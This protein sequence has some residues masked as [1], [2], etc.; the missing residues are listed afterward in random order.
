[1]PSVFCPLSPAQENPR[2]LLGFDFGIKFIGIAVGQTVTRT[3]KPL[4]ALKAH[5][6]VPK[7]DQVKKIIDTWRPSALVVGLPLNMDGTNQAITHL[8]AAFA[9]E[10]SK[11]YHL[12]VHT[13]DER[14]TTVEA[15]ARL[16]EESGYKAL[17][18]SKI[19]AMAARLILEAWMRL[20]F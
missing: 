18:K 4:M 7:W 2:T 10:L 13:I 9:D 19:D 14:L 17:E 20:G 15:K 5:E 8:A 1:M 16:F 3:A 12:P 6:G 11:R